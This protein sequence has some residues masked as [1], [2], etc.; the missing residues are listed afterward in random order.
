[1]VLPTSPGFENEK[2]SPRVVAGVE[3][4]NK[5]DFCCSWSGSVFWERSNPA[6]DL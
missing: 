6:M 4:V 3:D 5:D 2:S 1:M